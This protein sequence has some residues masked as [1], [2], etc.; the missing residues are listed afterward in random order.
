MLA[1][2]IFGLP[3]TACLTPEGQLTREERE[4]CKRMAGMCGRGA[5]PASHPCCKTTV[6]PGKDAVVEKIR[7]A[8]PA[9]DAVIAENAFN[10]APALVALAMRAFVAPSPPESS[11]PAITVLR[12]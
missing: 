3:T 10:S 5:M 6:Q 8:I 11:P 12:I 2:L 1:V 4:C 7:S 9:L